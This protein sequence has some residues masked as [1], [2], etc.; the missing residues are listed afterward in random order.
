MHQRRI[1]HVA[2]GKGHNIDLL[3]ADNLF[4][5]VFFQD[6][7]AFGV[8]VSRQF[9][10]ITSSSN[11]GDLCGSEGNYVEVGVVTKDYVEVV[12]I[13]SSRTKDEDSLHSALKASLDP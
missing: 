12:E 4:H 2:V 6:G 5:P 7:N 11:V 10:G 9:C 3:I 13:S 8:K 1:G